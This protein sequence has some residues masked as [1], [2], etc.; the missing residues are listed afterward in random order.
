[1][2]TGTPRKVYKRV[3]SVWSCRRATLRLGGRERLRGADRPD[4]IVSRTDLALV[5]LSMQKLA[6]AMEE[7]E[8]VA[9]DSERVLGR[10]HSITLRSR[11]S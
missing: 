11:S 4:T 9:A 3:I 6:A 7:Y 5:Y 2:S 8:R 10:M 1:M